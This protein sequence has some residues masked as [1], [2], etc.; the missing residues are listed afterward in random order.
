M[1]GGRWD[2]LQFKLN[3]RADDLR[4]A[5][6]ALDMLAAIEHEMDWGASGDTCYA[7]AQAR[8]IAALEAFFDANGSDAMA[9]MAIARDGK[10]NL[11]Q[12]HSEQ[13]QRHG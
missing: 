8:V 5:A 7:C 1:S 6:T 4:R 11:C 13:E 3:E 2:Y 9:A 10:Q 12:K